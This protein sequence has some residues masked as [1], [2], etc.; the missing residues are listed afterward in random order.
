MNIIDSNKKPIAPGTLDPDQHQAKQRGMARWK[1]FLAGNTNPDVYLLEGRLVVRLVDAA[2]TSKKDD[3]DD[4]YTVYE[5][6]D[7]HYYGLLN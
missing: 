1:P 4:T 6:K 7:G 3:Y 5:A 2:V